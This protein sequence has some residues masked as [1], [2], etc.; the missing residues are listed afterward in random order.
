MTTTETAQNRSDTTRELVPADQ[1]DHQALY[2]T[3]RALARCGERVVEDVQHDRADVHRDVEALA[4]AV[5]KGKRLL[6][7]EPPPESPESAVVLYARA[8]REGDKVFVRDAWFEV[9]YVWA[10]PMGGITWTLRGNHGHA[11]EFTTDPSRPVPVLRHPRNMPAP[12]GDA[13][14]EET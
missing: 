2:E 9:E 3:V 7:P 10:P 14:Q 8:V 1:I 11:D 4:A 12:D 6:Y 13:G 5:E